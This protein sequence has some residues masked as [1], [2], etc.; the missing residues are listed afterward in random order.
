MVVSLLPLPPLSKDAGRY[1]EMRS[2]QPRV[3]QLAIAMD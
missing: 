3:S 2:L 1:K